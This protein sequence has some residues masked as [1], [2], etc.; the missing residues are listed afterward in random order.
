MQIWEREIHANFVWRP[1]ISMPPPSLHALDQIDLG[2]LRVLLDEDGEDAAAFSLADCLLALSADATHLAVGRGRR[3]LL[4]PQQSAGMPLSLPLHA[5]DE[6]RSLTW[7]HRGEQPLL[8]AGLSSGRLS[9]F[10]P[11]HGAEPLVWSARLHRAPLVQLSHGADLSLLCL[12]ADGLV[13]CAPSAESWL[14]SAPSSLWRW[15]LPSEA[16]G[17]L[18]MSGS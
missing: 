7:L 6:V 2:L 4:L 3:L 18:G 14:A 1:S 8:V 17:R 10:T 13:V 11:E 12:F 5:A 15:S 16:T 9:A